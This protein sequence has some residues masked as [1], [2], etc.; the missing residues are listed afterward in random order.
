MQWLRS[1]GGC[2]LGWGRFWVVLGLVAGMVSSIECMAKPLMDGPY[3]RL[4]GLIDVGQPRRAA[5]SFRQHLAANADDHEARAGLARALSAMNRCDESLVHLERLRGTSAFSAKVAHS[6]AICHLRGGEHSEAIAAWEEALLMNPQLLPARYELARLLIREGFYLQA[7]DQI[8]AIET[9]STRSHRSDILKVEL[10][11]H[12]G[13]GAWEAWQD[14][15]DELGPR[16][17]KQA[18]QQVHYLEGHLWL[19]E[20]DPVEAEACFGRAVEAMSAHENSVIYRA[21]ALRRMGLPEEAREIVYRRV[22]RDSPFLAPIRARILADLGDLSAAR[23]E[24][25]VREDFLSSEVLA[26]QWYLAKKQGRPSEHWRDM[27]VLQN[28]WGA[29]GLEALLPPE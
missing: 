18:V 13:E 6:E 29:T 21:E 11:L 3:A 12:R 9:Q 4:N 15:K 2:P 17:S 19:Q 23:A 5:P 25:A 27:W 22:L 28:H 16:S 24:L 14:F 10:A 20:G 1:D 26:S 8:E 7:L